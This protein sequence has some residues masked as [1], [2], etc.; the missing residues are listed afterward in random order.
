MIL[1]GQ[2]LSKNSQNNSPLHL[3]LALHLKTPTLEYRHEKSAG[4]RGSQRGFI[5]EITAIISFNVSKNILLKEFVRIY[6]MI[7][8]SEMI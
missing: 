6:S 5:L 3:P 8:G 2:D 7:Y 4:I 1:I